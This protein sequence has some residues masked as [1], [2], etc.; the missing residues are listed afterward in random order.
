MSTVIQWRVRVQIRWLEVTVSGEETD[1]TMPRQNFRSVVRIH[2]LCWRCRR[3]NSLLLLW[4]PHSA[5]QWCPVS[6]FSAQPLSDVASD[7][8]FKT[9]PGQKVQKFSNKKRVLAFACWCV[10]E[11]VLVGVVW[12]FICLFNNLRSLFTNDV[13]L[14][15]EYE[16][17]WRF[18]YP[19]PLRLLILKNKV[20]IT[21]TSSNTIVCA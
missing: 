15:F 20:L 3:R 6:P 21:K 11:W 12:D 5:G 1:K 9:V 8:K 7:Q 18:Q 2:I 19:C 16:V 10:H 17:N 13:L 14:L 4:Q